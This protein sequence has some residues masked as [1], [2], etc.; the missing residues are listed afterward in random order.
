MI[1]ADVTLDTF[2]FKSV[3][4]YKNDSYSTSKQELIKPA[5]GNVDGRFARSESYLLP[6]EIVI[7]ATHRLETEG[8]AEK[9]RERREIKDRAKRVS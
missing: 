3:E 9:G 5:S 8:P 6:R 2:Y 4:S 1:A 7:A